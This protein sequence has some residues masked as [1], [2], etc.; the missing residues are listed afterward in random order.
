[1]KRFI[2]ILITAMFALSSM[3]QP[4]QGGGMGKREFS[5]EDFQK[6]MEGFIA[7]RAGLT[8]EECT[9]FFPLLHEMFEA[10]RALGKKQRNKMHVPHK[11]LSEDDSKQIILETIQM[12]NQRRKI[13]EI[14]YTKHFPKV[15]S[16][17]KI[18]KVR[19]AVESFKY[20]ALKRFSPMNRGKGPEN[21]K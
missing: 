3:A 14:Y 8:P 12:D 15:L 6:H 21:K 9:K 13:E 18:L 10:Q 19:Y 20:E 5:P 11:E 16:W 7:F 2:F 1:M 4:P 17:K